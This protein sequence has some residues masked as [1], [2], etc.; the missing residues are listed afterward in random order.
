MLKWASQVWILLNEHFAKNYLLNWA[1]HLTSWPPDLWDQKEEP[2]TQTRCQWNHQLSLAKPFENPLYFYSSLNLWSWN[3]E[4]SFKIFFEL[5]CEPPVIKV[6]NHS[7]P[8][9]LKIFS[10]DTFQQT[11]HLTKVATFPYWLNR[12][13]S[14]TPNLGV[15]V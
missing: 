11:T 6:C 2:S 7:S 1:E 14:G 9:R 10:P 12:E 8:L 13:P 5:L 4:E 15:W 3:L